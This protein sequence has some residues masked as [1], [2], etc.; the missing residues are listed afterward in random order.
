[1][2]PSTIIRVCPRTYLSVNFRSPVA[3]SSRV[4]S[5]AW[6]TGMLALGDDSE[7]DDAENWLLW[8]SA[9][10]LDEPLSLLTIRKIPITTPAS[11]TMPAPPPIS[12]Q[13]SRGFERVFSPSS[14]S[15]SRG[16]ARFRAGVGRG[17][18]ASIWSSSRFAGGAALALRAGTR[19]SLSRAG[20]ANALSHF[21]QRI[22]L[23]A[24]AV[25]DFSLASQC[26]QTTV[27]VAM[28][29]SPMFANDRAGGQGPRDCKL[30]YAG[31]GDRPETARGVGTGERGRRV[32]LASAAG[33]RQCLLSLFDA[34]GSDDF[35]LEV[36]RGDLRSVERRGREIRAERGGHENQ[37]VCVCR[38]RMASAC[39]F[40]YSGGTRRY[41]ALKFWLGFLANLLM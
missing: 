14:S 37:C 17:S 30:S 4:R 41:A 35:R 39:H 34:R 1:M 31:R 12:P 7:L 29:A 36:D 6:T 33:S 32:V 2:A 16:R 3:S 9:S 38:P 23:P 21:G 24:L 11:T 26:G 20:T 5:V 8:F 22:F 25:D 27:S 19:T 28:T 40:P 15:S 10:E 18:A 13:R